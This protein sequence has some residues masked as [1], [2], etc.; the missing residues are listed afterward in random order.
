MTEQME[1]FEIWVS[2]NGKIR[3]QLISEKYAT[4]IVGTREV[5]ESLSR[6][7]EKTFE[8]MDDAGIEAL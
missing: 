7:L 3:L 1:Q 6:R 2:E 8:R 5:W 4:E